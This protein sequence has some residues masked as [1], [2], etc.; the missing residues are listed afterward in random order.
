MQASSQAEFFWG[1]PEYEFHKALLWKVPDPQAS[2]PP[3]PDFPSWAWGGWFKAPY[4]VD[5]ADVRPLEEP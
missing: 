5:T 1:L 2:S 4:H 3:R